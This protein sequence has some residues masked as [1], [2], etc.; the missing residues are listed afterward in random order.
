VAAGKQLPAGV[1]LENL[2]DF[3]KREADLIVE[4]CPCPQP[5]AVVHGS[6]GDSSSLRVA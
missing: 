3:D 2:D 6:S 4:V 1:V 5:G